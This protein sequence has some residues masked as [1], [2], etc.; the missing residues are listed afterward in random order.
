MSLRPP[1]FIPLNYV[2]ITSPITSNAESSMTRFRCKQL[3]GIMLWQS[4]KQSNYVIGIDFLQ[5]QH[6]AARRVAVQL[7]ATPGG[8]FA[9]PFELEDRQPLPI[10]SLPRVASDSRTLSSSVQR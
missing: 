9:H 7:S 5:N 4:R 10:R 2:R 1:R 3:S 6:N 8:L